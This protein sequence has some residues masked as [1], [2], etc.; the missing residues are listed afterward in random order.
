MVYQN[1]N[2][3]TMNIKCFEQALSCVYAAE[4][5]CLSP[6]FLNMR[7]VIVENTI[8]RTNTT[9]FIEWQVPVP[10]PAMCMDVVFSIPPYTFTVEY[11]LR[12][13]D[14]TPPLFSMVS[15]DWPNSSS[16]RIT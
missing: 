14:S 3:C 16:R 15:F 12:S 13:G 6:N 10:L 8:I 1:L 5:E 9:V 11:R 7:P 4:Q 2:F